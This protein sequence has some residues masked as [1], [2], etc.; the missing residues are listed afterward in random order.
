[1]SDRFVY[2]LLGGPYNGREVVRGKLHQ[3]SELYYHDPY[4]E[5]SSS[6]VI[7]GRTNPYTE[8]PLELA[9]W[10]KKPCPPGQQREPEFY[11]G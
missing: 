1:M 6:L 8:W 3:R 5:N 10:G 9:Y 11:P 4:A 2:K 7:Y